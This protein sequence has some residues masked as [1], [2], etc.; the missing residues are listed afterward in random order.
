MPSSLL[1]T[2]T[3]NIPIWY[4]L[5]LVKLQHKT[6]AIWSRA[7]Q[8]CLL[9]VAMTLSLPRLCKQS[10]DLRPVICDS[11]RSVTVEQPGRRSRSCAQ[12]A[13]GRAGRS[14]GTGQTARDALQPGGRG[15]VASTTSAEVIW[16]IFFAQKT[17]QVAVTLPDFFFLVLFF[18]S[19]TFSD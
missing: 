14:A 12:P 2:C 13:A 3:S 19:Q 7:K 8:N 5:P 11:K 10:Q 1:W 16:S 6:S 4:Y 9:Q 15:R 18:P 17:S